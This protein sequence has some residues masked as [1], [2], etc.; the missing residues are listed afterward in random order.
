M[1]LTKKQFNALPLKDVVSEERINELH[2]DI[3]MNK[4]HRI[5]MAGH[6]HEMFRFMYAQVKEDLTKELRDE[7]YEMYA[8][9]IRLA[10]LH[11]STQIRRGNQYEYDTD[12]DSDTEPDAYKYKSTANI[13]TSFYGTRS[14]TKKRIRK[15]RNLQ[16]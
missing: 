4:P 14:S 11:A 12:T 13:E 9:P 3:E 15:Q 8:K 1:M 5:Y 2:R 7:A 6:R 16:I 10:A